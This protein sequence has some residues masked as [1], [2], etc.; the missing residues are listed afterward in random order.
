VANSFEYILIKD[1]HFMFG[2]RNNIRKH[3]W[4]R[5]IDYKIDQIIN[6]ARDNNITNLFFTGDIFEK[7]RKKDWS[8]N[9]FQQNKKRL[10]KFYDAGIK[11]FSNAGN[12]DYFDGRESVEG[13]AFGEMVELG[14]ITHVG[15]DQ[16]PHRF[17]TEGGNE[18]LLFGIDYHQ[19]LTEV[20]DGIQMVSAYQKQDAAIKLLLLH[21][22]VTDKNIQLTDFTYQQLSEYDIDVINCGHWHLVP[23]NGA[24]QQLNNTWFLNPW[25]L[26]R[27]SRDYA[28]K[29]DEHRPEF[30]HAKI[31]FVPEPVFDF[32]EIYLETRKFSEAF[33]IDI[34]NMLQELGK[35]EF[36]FFKNIELE[37][38]EDIN[39]D[40]KL[41]E[42]LA[43]AHK[44]TKESIQ[45]AKELL[46]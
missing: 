43:E 5:D 44:I 12:H 13:T 45:I 36:D 46:T 34:I 31:N 30:I 27:V 14:L 6:Y 28:V 23:E 41:L 26:T 9:Q 39:S 40:E 17:V 42:S 35:S 8:L 21:S 38:D 11:V 24:V 29:L 4:E 3:G 25:N 16:V 33:N 32:K 15:H 19:S 10:I 18:V 7:S 37:Q 20:L 2:F 1:P 22:N